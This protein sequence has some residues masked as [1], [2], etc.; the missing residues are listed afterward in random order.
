MRMWGLMLFVSVAGYLF[1]DTLLPLLTGRAEYRA[2][3]PLYLILM[4]GI[5]VASG[6]VPFGLLLVNGGFPGVQSLMVVLIVLTNTL[7][8]FIL[9][10]F[11]GSIGAA[12]ATTLANILSVVLLKF[13]ARRC[14]CVSV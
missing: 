10:P 1:V 7:G 13:F 12:V 8:N 11:W 3:A 9:I 14:L 6:Y 4:A 2:A 5:T